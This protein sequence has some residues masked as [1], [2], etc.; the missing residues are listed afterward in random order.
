MSLVP[1]WKV[2][3][4]LPFS[5]LT[6]MSFA[7]AVECVGAVQVTVRTFWLPLVSLLSAYDGL[8]QVLPPI[9]VVM[10]VRTLV[11]SITTGKVTL[12]CTC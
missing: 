2:Y 1:L 3:L 5:A 7:P 12:I 11:L 9:V 6:T 4:K 8:V 10:L